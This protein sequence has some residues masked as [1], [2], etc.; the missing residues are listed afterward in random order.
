MTCFT[1]TAEVS[2][3]FFLNNPVKWNYFSHNKSQ[4][5]PSTGFLLVFLYTGGDCYLQRMEYESFLRNYSFKFPNISFLEVFFLNQ[6][7]LKL[8]F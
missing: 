8:Y 7:S 5:E 3:L 2:V 6:F 1:A 4:K